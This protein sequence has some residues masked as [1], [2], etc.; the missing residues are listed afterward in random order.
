MISKQFHVND[1]DLV[2]HKIKYEDINLLKDDV[3][4]CYNLGDKALTFIDDGRIIFICGIKLFRPGVG[5]CW[6]IPSVYV[7]NYK[8][9][10]VK[11]IRKLIKDNFKAMNLHRLHTT[12]VDDFVGWIEYMGFKRESVLE[13]IGSDKTNEYMYVRFS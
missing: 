7:D 12:I 5:Q 2:N 9:S 13:K 8:V 11:T 6:I 3:Y 4:P 1:I 10:F